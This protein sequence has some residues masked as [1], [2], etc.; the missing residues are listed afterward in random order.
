[1]HKAL[2]RLEKLLKHKSGTQNLDIVHIID[3]YGDLVM[4]ICKRI[5]IDDR[6]V[7]E[8]T[9]DTFV[10][11]YKNLDR[12]RADCSLKTW[13]YR[14]AYHTAIDYTRKKKQKLVSYEEIPFDRPDH[15]AGNP[16]QNMEDRE[17]KIWVQN[18]IGHLPPEQAALIT[19]YYM[20]EKNVKEVSEITGLSESNVKI[21]LFR[22]RKSLAEILVKS[23][24]A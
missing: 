9:Q 8:A 7:E 10:K 2:E 23:Q 18:S 19:L 11:A 24:N 1:M 15:S 3:Q 5:L 12:F 22:A 16:H 14:I 17:Q 6:L 13:I 20:E 21:K 4:T